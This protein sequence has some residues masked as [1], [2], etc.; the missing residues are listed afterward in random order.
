MSKIIESLTK[1][2]EAKIPVYVEKF[3]ALGL[4]TEPVDRE[5]AE[6]AVTASYIYQKLPAPKF[7]WADSP[8]KGIVI[9]AQLAEG[10]EDV[11]NQEIQK[12]AALANYGS[13]NAYWVAGYSFI[14]NELPV[15]K[16]ELCGIVED[17]VK[18]CGVYW[19]FEDVVVMTDKPIN[20]HMSKKGELHN[21]DGLA[22]EYKDGTGVFAI[23]GVRYPSLLAMTIEEAAK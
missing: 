9:A 6:A 1:E 5:K 4:S 22:L 20:I 7:I 16:D 17:I 2:Q 15:T 8:T 13:F 12:Q 11:T 18:T 23:N 10:K 14:A 3:K 21:P 19:T